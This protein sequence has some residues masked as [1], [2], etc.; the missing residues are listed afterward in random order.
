MTQSISR[1]SVL[2]SSLLAGAALGAGV[3]GQSA[4]ADDDTEKPA[5][6]LKVKQSVMAW[7]FNPMPMEKLIPAC[8]EIGLAGM[9][10]INEKFYPLMK[11]HG[12]AVS[13]CGSHGFKTGPVNP[14]NH[15]ECIAKL[16]AGI[17]RAV[18]WDCKSVI[19]FTGMR[20]QGISDRQASE[21]AAPASVGISATRAAN[22]ERPAMPGVRS[23][24]A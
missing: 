2:K 9:E 14:D 12:L 10:G 24:L 13:L 5:G 21:K 8:A 19:T 23:R 4:S 22:P 11:Q 15:A 1:R 18:A 16:R 20:E 6:K 3:A 7:C 17:D